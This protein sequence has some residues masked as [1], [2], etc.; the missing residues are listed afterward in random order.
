M[1]KKTDAGEQIRA[2]VQGSPAAAWGRGFLGAVI[3]GAIGFF[4][5]KWLLT[6][7]YYGLALPAILLAIGFSMG[8][9]RSMVLGDVFCAIA[10]LAIM[11]FSE[12]YTSPLVKDMSLRFFL[13]N[14]AELQ[15]VTLIF[16]A[17]GTA[18]AFWFGKG[19]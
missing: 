3:G 16:I 11:I 13:R 2:I 4:A 14:L 5:F 10:G 12:W 7:G 19:R 15:P 6:Q 1:T 17:V 8:S 9:R 18:V